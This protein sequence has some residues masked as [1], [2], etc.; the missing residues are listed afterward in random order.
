MGMVFPGNKTLNNIS[1]VRIRERSEKK[2]SKMQWTVQAEEGPRRVNHAAVSV[3]DR[4]V[5]SFGGFYSCDEYSALE[6]MDVHI[7]DMS[8]ISI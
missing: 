5:F 2:D 1:S 7:F 6:K 8:T 3:K 4:Y